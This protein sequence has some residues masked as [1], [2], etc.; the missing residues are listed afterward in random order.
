[1]SK[2]LRD[3][4]LAIW[5]AAVDAIRPEKLL[6]NAVQRDASIR[7]ALTSAERILVIGAGKAGAAMSAAFE[8]ALDG[9]LNKVEG[10]VNVPANVVRLSVGLETVDD[11][12][13][14][15]DRAIGKAVKKR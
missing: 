15:V 12:L 13:T 4:A 6:S 10:I 3:Q 1:M 8:A 5:Q 2:P 11:L 9:Q 7:T 14:D